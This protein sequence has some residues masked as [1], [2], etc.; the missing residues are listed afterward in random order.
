MSPPMA[1]EPFARSRLSP[2]ALPLP[3]VRPRPPAPVRPSPPRVAA[4]RWSAAGT[5]ASARTVRAEGGGT[6]LSFLLFNQRRGRSGPRRLGN[7][8][9]T[10]PMDPLA[11]S[12]PS[13]R[14]VLASGNALRRRSVAR[15]QAPASSPPR[16]RPQA[17][18]PRDQM[19][20]P[21]SPLAESS[22]LRSS[23][24]LEESPR[25]KQTA[26]PGLFRSR[27]HLSVRPN[28]VIWRLRVA[29]AADLEVECPLIRVVR[30][31]VDRRLLRA[32]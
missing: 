16:L 28:G 7:Q 24:R 1:A 26:G 22:V 29:P 4:A 19:V 13:A 30:E 21:P 6:E 23:S 10:P 14:R 32:R 12:R 18:R 20:T 2:L 11:T 5:L 27:R 17:I 8:V 31:D 9:C 25:A 15:R 3:R